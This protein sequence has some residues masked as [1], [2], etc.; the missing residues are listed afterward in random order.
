M[1][2][3]NTTPTTLATDL[4][5]LGLNRTAED[6]NDIIATA[7]RKRWST[8][9]LLEHIA[10]AELEERQRRSVERRLACA[11]LGRFKPLADWDWNWPTT[12]DR[13]ALERILTLDFLAAAR[14]SSSSAP[15]VS[16]RPCS[17][18]TS[19]T[20]PSSPGTPPS[21]PPPP[22][23]CSTSAGRRPPA[24]SN[25]AQ[26]LHPARAG[27]DRRGRLPRLRRPRRRPHL[28]A[29][30]PPLRAPLPADHHQPA[31]QALGH[32]LPQRFLRRC[33]DRPPDPSRRDPPH[34]GPELPPPRGE[35]TQ[36]RRG[37]KRPPRKR[38]SAN[39]GQP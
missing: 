35:L 29:R 12:L 30:Q 17:P 3:D 10:A 34:R 26:A 4:R 19:P 36:Q 23:S 6:L 13:P 38:A 31:L 9:A 8:T 25:D 20:K 33:P 28:P 37:R 7:T 18:R 14:T 11:R 5:R 22:T 15:R 2:S 21:S 1:T 39:G 24:P 32:R 27:R 16:A